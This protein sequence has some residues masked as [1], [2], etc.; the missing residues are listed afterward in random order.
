[1]PCRHTIA[2]V[3]IFLLTINKVALTAESYGPVSFRLKLEQAWGAVAKGIPC[4]PVF[5][6]VVKL[7]FELRS[8]NI[9]KLVITQGKVQTVSVHLDQLKVSTINEAVKKVMVELQNS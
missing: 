1:M 2:G 6:S 5:F 7:C 9:L 8:H 4:Q 3:L